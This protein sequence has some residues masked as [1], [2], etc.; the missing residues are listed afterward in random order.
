MT[1]LSPSVL[2]LIRLN[3]LSLHIKLWQQLK[4]KAPHRC[5]D[6]QQFGTFQSLGGKHGEFDLGSEK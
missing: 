6:E 3:S 5:G 4:R 2:V 1:A